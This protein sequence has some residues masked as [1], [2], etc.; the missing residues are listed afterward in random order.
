[1]CVTLPS[2]LKTF[3][4]EVLDPDGIEVEFGVK[5][6]AEAGAVIANTSAGGHLAP[7]SPG[8]APR[9]TDGRLA[10]AGRVDTGTD[11]KWR[12]AQGF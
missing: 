9:V 8:P 5:F 11:L 1:M 10:V 6:N 4:A 7:S 2:A 3:R 12:L